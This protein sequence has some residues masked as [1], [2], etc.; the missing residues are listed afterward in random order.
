MRWPHVKA[1]TAAGQR[2][3]FYAETSYAAYKQAID[4]FKPKRSRQHM[5]SVHL[6]EKDAAPGQPG[7]RR[8][9]WRISDW[10]GTFP[11]K[12]EDHA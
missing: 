4:H 3:E 7:R 1:S 12:G 6:A 8:S 9:T 10:A 5:V 11:G 2:A